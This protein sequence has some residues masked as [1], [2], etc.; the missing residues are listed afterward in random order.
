MDQYSGK[1][2]Q[3]HPENITLKSLF[4]GVVLLPKLSLKNKS[5][6]FPNQPKDPL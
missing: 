6:A 5:H 3:A 2:P 4:P 1:V